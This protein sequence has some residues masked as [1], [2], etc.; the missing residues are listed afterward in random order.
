MIDRLTQ[1]L[2]LAYA[3]YRLPIK[4]HTDASTS[5]L[6]AVLY[7]TQNGIDRVVAY[8]S[9]SLKPAEKNYPVHKLEF[10]ALKWAVTDKFYNYL[11]GL[12]FEALMDNNRLTYALT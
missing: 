4:L 8:A 2:V 5:G 7:Q 12:K 9:R 1:P 3:D 10:L 11:Y 6:G